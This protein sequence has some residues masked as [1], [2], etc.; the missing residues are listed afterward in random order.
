MEGVSAESMEDIPQRL[1]RLIA[2]HLD[3]NTGLLQ[4]PHIEE[5]IFNDLKSNSR[6]AIY[7]A[8]DFLNLKSLTDL[9]GPELADQV[10]RYVMSITDLP[11][12]NESSS[13]VNPDRF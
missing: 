9:L 4:A 6:P 10:M 2:L 5:A 13:G 8:G 12:I 11:P 1:Q 3:E 7:I